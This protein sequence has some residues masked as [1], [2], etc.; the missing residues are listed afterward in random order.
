MIGAG[1]ALTADLLDAQGQHQGGLLA[2]G[3]RLLQQCLPQAITTLPPAA[4]P[5]SPLALAQATAPALTQ[6]AWA[7][8]AGLVERLQAQYAPDIVLLHGG[9]ARLLQTVLRIPCQV[10]PELVLQ[11]LACWLEETRCAA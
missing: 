8:A 1:T 11:G 7:C 9:D 3:L 6:G 10:M 5:T 2:P 4:P